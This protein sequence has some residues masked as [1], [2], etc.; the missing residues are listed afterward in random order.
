MTA[1]IGWL[2][3]CK[4]GFVRLSAAVFVLWALAADWG[5]RAARLAMGELPGFDYAAEVASLRQEG[6]FGEALVMA[7]EG[8]GDIDTLSVEQRDALLAERDRVVAERDSWKRRLRD[9]GTGALT[10]R[11]D[12]LEALAGT[13][14]ADLFVVGDVRDLIIQSWNMLRGGDTDEL[15][16]AL[17]G[18][19]LATTLAPEVDWAPSL[20]KAARKVGSMSKGLGEGVLKAIR[21]GRNEEVLRIMGDVGVLARHA[22]PAGALRAMKHA[23]D[24]EDLARLARFLER[25]GG[26]AAGAGEDAA[27]AAARLEKDGGGALALHVFEGDALDVLRAGDALGEPARAERVLV[28]AARHGRAGRGFVRAGLATPLLKP[29]PLVGL[30]KALHKGTAAALVDELLERADAHAWWIT[31]AALAWAVVEAGLI[32]ARTPTRRRRR[33]PLADDSPA[34][35]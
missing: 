16:L 15:V 6:R 11:G 4:W 35:S 8:L 17:S 1:W 2:W 24:P 25:R 20:L 13:V 26:G 30:L 27:R 29:H 28:R 19:G 31:A 21:K 18:V 12:S 14:V 10:G 9:A 33:A 22:S 7:D 3:R 23:D 34:A 32:A 5:A